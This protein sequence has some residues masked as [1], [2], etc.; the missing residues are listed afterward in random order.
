MDLTHRFTDIAAIENIL[1]PTL[2]M[3]RIYSIRKA[4]SFSSNRFTFLF[5]IRE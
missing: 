3:N 2:G 1:Y 4:T 5:L